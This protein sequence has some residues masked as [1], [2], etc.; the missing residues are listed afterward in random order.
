MHTE[1]T[2]PSGPP[3]HLDVSASSSS[4]LQ[5]SWAP[6]LPEVQNGKI[7]GYTITVGVI[8]P[9][10]L[11]P[12][13]YFVAGDGELLFNLEGL[14]PFTNY[15]ITVSA[16][17]QVGPG[18]PTSPQAIQTPEDGKYRYVGKPSCGTFDCSVQTISI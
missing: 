1:S 11:S 9:Q 18:P 13:S 14:H 12:Q 2:A 10:Q 4:S 16:S 7:V 5:I 17:T 6:P 8:G 3:Q 15:S